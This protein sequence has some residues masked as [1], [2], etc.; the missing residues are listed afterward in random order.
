MI[1]DTS[2]CTVCSMPLL[3]VFGLGQDKWLG[4]IRKAQRKVEKNIY[5][6]KGLQQLKDQWKKM[7]WI[8]D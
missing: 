2:G 6:N 3:A 1:P 4:L 5:D 8:D 7:G